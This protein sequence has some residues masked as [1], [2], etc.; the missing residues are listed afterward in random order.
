M[1]EDSSNMPTFLRTKFD[2]FVLLSGDE[3]SSDSWQTEAEIILGAEDC[4]TLRAY[5]WGE[6]SSEEQL[7]DTV[8]YKDINRRKHSTSLSNTQNS[9]VLESA[10][11]K[12]VVS[13]RVTV[14]V[15]F[16]SCW[17]RELCICIQRSNWVGLEIS[18]L[19]TASSLVQHLCIVQFEPIC[20]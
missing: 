8:R 9:F 16:R 7:S 18:W 1:D 19:Y 10:G 13:S 5:G 6:Q 4:S 12:V 17:I 3:R 11:Y 20:K 14:A 15:S 2:Y